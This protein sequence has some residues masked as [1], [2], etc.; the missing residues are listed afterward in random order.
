MPTGDQRTLRNVVDELAR[1]FQA[2]GIATSRQDARLIVEKASGASATDLI[3]RP[4]LALAD[5]ALAAIAAAAA[6]R[7]A[8]EPVHRIFGRREFY[9]LPFDLSPA[10][11]EPR[12][13]T[14][15]LVDVAIAFARRCV[16][17]TGSC[18]LI[19]LGTGSG[20][21]AVAILH[22]VPA[23]TA[24]ATDIDGCAL[25]TAR[26]NADLNG[27]GGRFDTICCD[28]FDEIEGRFDLIVSNP[29][30]IAHVAMD[31]LSPEVRLFDPRAALDGGEDGLAAYRRIAGGAG[32][33]LAP[34]G[35]IAVEIGWDQ[36]EAV[37]A[38][39]TQAGFM[40]ESATKD[41]AGHERV[42]AFRARQ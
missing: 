14:E 4:E 6:R 34:D 16:A 39:F 37:G 11:L 20:A 13:D 8:Y 12:P 33:F 27:V 38:I 25:E 22:N 30:Y 18:R 7:L 21:I 36:S 10:T 26:G 41:L 35:L 32:R 17:E 3:A 42:L 28:W 31:E 40:A 2:A 19:D 24:L 15:T 29:P 9:G 23:A 1:R 5:E